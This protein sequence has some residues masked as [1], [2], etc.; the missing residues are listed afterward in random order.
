MK[1][2]QYG[3]E[4]RHADLDELENLYTILGDKLRLVTLA[5]EV[6]KGLEAVD[7][8]VERGI[9]V[10]IGH[11]DASYEQAVEGFERGITHGTHT[12]NGMR[13]L[14]HREPGVVGAILATPGVYAELIADLVHVH[15]GAIRVLLAS[16]G[17]DEL[18]W[19][20]M[21]CR[22]QDYLMVSMF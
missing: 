12:F 15:P 13:G 6:P 7:W 18:F 9:T 22:L 10:S 1:G 14:H 4:I 21:R 16:K 3:P 17:I 11:S 20:P 5:P 8:L 19:S 2:A